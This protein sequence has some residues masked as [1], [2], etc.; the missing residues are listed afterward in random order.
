MN[1]KFEELKASDNFPSPAGIALEI[2]RMAQAEETDIADV[3]RAVQADPVLTGRVLKIAN[4]AAF[5]NTRPIIS[6]KDAIIKI[7]N[8]ILS[9]LA[10]S[11]SVLN[12]TKQ[13]HCISLDYR[14][15]WSS[16]LQRALALQE[17]AKIHPVICPEE[18]FTVGLISDVGRLAL[19][20]VYPEEFKTCEESTRYSNLEA[21]RALF[22]IDQNQVTVAILSD[23][24]LPK[25]VIDAITYFHNESFPKAVKLIDSE[26]LSLQLKL[27]YALIEESE[28][29]LENSSINEI[30]QR[31]NISN[32]HLSTILKNI[33]SQWPEWLSLLQ[34]GD[35]NSG[36]N[37]EYSYI[38]KESLSLQVISEDSNQLDI[39][40]SYS[41]KNS[42]GVI[43]SHNYES[44]LKDLVTY[45]PQIVIMGYTDNPDSIL[46]FCK[47]IRANK[48]FD[49]T[50][51]ILV[52]HENN[53]DQLLSAYKAGINDI[54]QNP[55]DDNSLSI[56]LLAA[57]RMIDIFNNNQ[58]ERHQLQR[59][60]F[61]LATETR[62]LENIALTDTLTAL[63][64]RRFSNRFLDVLWNSFLHNHK[65][66]GILSIDLDF[67]KKINDK[68]GHSIGD[69]VL[70]HFSNILRDV[71]G[72]NDIAC[73]WGGEEFIVISQNINSKLLATLSEKIR[74]SVENNQPDNLKLSSLVT[75]SIG[76]AI[77]NF[78]QDEKGW[79]DTLR[80]SDEAL[81]KAKS[82]GRN[83]CV[84]SSFHHRHERFYH[85]AEIKITNHA[86]D[87]KTLF[88]A[89]MLNLSKSGVFL[90]CKTSHLPAVDDILQIQTSEIE[91]A[92]WRK[93][94]VIRVTDNGFSVEFIE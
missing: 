91:N 2:L 52:I 66:F 79:C 49:S 46:T 54:I 30:N 43:S 64:N 12:K 80:R 31:L 56:K 82:T 29:E 37:T 61:K 92:E 39:I 11:L 48:Q 78:K 5:N 42:Y 41:I 68:H 59:H 21:Q 15:F 89:T 27:A 45:K 47:S 10:L 55:L 85:Q 57:K 44:A 90:K 19:A 84:I 71:I 14:N 93:C 65:S 83:K 6:V 38:K 72:P 53:I 25:L 9:R 63:K 67:F 73:R 70:V 87:P 8:G 24:S 20:Q 51:M 50:Y 17:I 34:I 33:D 74:E 58:Y 16:S 28:F 22:G 86:N 75:V 4:S 40:D 13:G 62:L 77:S 32:E 26:K 3:A 1:L 7:G 60:A 23:W 76:G 69:Q 36:P 88:T 18:A 35:D 81:Y 94:R